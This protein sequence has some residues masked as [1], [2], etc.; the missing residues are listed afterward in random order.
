MDGEIEGAFC[1]RGVRDGGECR[2]RKVGEWLFERPDDS[3]FE[4]EKV[5]LYLPSQFRLG[6]TPVM[7]IQGG[8]YLL[9]FPDELSRGTPSH[10]SY[11]SVVMRCRT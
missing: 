2:E 8:W 10:P 9:Y 5:A 7:E 6:V 1:D 11:G 4:E 3:R